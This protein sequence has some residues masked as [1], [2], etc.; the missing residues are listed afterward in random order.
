M[1]VQLNKIEKVQNSGSH[2]HEYPIKTGLGS[3]YF[4]VRENA[5]NFF[6]L[7]SWEDVR[8][9][10]IELLAGGGHALNSLGFECQEKIKR[11]TRSN[12]L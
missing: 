4:G 1:R 11:W 6:E 7:I 5:W 3:I 8:K 12:R 9:H 10:T 2:V